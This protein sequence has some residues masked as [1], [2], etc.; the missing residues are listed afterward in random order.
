MAAEP[1]EAEQTASPPIKTTRDD[2]RRAVL[3]MLLA[4]IFL[5]LLNA[6]IQY[7]RPSFP[8]GQ[9]LWARYAGHLAFM[10]IVFAPGRGT[11]LLASARPGLQVA[12]SILFCASTLL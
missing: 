4:A 2:Y 9:L 1:K 11:A 8:V 5:P 12:R 3:F 7:L 6:A 10:L